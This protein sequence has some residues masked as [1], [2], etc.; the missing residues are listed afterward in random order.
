MYLKTE[1]KWSCIFPFFF[2][3]D[4]P[5]AH[6]RS[7]TRDWIH[8]T[9]ATQ[10]TAVNNTGSLTCCATRKLLL[11]LLFNIRYSILPLAIF[12]EVLFVFQGVNK[13]T[14]DNMSLGMLI[15]LQD[16]TLNST[17]ICIILFDP[18]NTSIGEPELRFPKRLTGIKIAT[19]KV[20]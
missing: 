4:A 13:M 6:A 9:A 16:S 3:L 10:A 20:N 2:F 18:S 11:S 7:R 17:F 12:K 5:G 19:L 8:A 14:N 15:F 1:S